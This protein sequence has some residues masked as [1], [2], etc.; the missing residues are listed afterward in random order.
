MENILFFLIGNLGSIQD[1]MVIIE[2]EGRIHSM[3]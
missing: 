2:K 1:G 3:G